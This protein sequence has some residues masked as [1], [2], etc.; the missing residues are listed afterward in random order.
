MPYLNCPRCGLSL[1]LR[2]PN[3]VRNPDDAHVCPRCRGQAGVT[4]PMYLT[5]RPRPPA[6]PVAEPKRAL[7]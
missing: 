6:V 5:D 3:D 2:T 4:V 7:A 1:T